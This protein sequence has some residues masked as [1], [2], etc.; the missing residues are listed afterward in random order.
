LRC[1]KKSQTKIV[2]CRWKAD[3]TIGASK[4]LIL[5]RKQER[6]RGG[7][8]PVAQC[9]PVKRES[10]TGQYEDLSPDALARLAQMKQTL[11]QEANTYRRKFR[12]AKR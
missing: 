10:W 6:R 5:S 1:C 11:V 8:T 4:T 3:G 9:I 2:S 7:G 12:A